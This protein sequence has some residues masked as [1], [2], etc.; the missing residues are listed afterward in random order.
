[1]STFFAGRDLLIVKTSESN[2]ENAKNLAKNI[3]NMKLAACISFC[4]I[5]S[6]Y[7]WEGK[8]EEYS[9]IEL[10][11]K[12]KLDLLDELFVTIKK[13]HSYKVPEFICLNTFASKEYVNWINEIKTNSC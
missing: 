6:M 1:M 5:N 13:N 10:T 2:Y 9:E 12:T 4:N 11:I 7:W 8:L 3:L